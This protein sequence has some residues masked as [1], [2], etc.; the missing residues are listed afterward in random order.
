MPL[1]WYLVYALPSLIFFTRRIVNSASESISM[2]C[3]AWKRFTNQIGFG[4]LVSSQERRP[5]AFLLVK[6]RFCSSIRLN[7]N[8]VVRASEESSRTIV[9]DALGSKKTVDS[10]ADRP[11][12]VPLY[13]APPCP[14]TPPRAAP[15]RSA[16]CISW[17]WIRQVF[18]K[19][20]RRKRPLQVFNKNVT[21][22]I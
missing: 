6:H 5:I 4:T 8:S 3:L 20:K 15:S 22:G 14:A 17:C 2:T 16:R 1:H 13:P 21:T 18:K 11:V 12:G 9:F 19:K 10:W 7:G